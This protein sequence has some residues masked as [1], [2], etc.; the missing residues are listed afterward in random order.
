[1]KKRNVF[2]IFIIFILIALSIYK[3]QNN[4]SANKTTTITMNTKAK[5]KSVTILA[6]KGKE[7]LHKFQINSFISMKTPPQFAIWLEDVNGNYVETLYVTSKIAKENWSK[8]K[9]QEVLP[10]W[11]YK[12]NSRPISADAVS[13]ATP[14]GS[15]A[16]KTNLFET[17]GK[18]VVCAEV[19]MSTD[20]NEY[21]KKDAVVGKD[22]YSGGAK[23]S[24]QPSIVYNA[25]VDLNLKN[26]IYELKPVGHSN[27]AGTDG[28]LYKD[29]SK[30]TTAKN[31]IKNIVVDIK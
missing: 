8:I 26:A 14:K 15:S 23:G 29:M 3:I 19:N 21:Y 2:L 31:I 20:F 22:N 9:K 6:I 11:N 24:G 17:Q 5:G 30:I 27:P 12:L 18:Y 4:I 16:I 28:K 10:Y 1:M 13:S 25:I 7:Y